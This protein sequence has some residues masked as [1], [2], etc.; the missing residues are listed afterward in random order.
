LVP[1]SSKVND[2]FTLNDIALVDRLRYNLLSVSQLVDVD[3]HVLFWKSDSRV[4]DS[5]GNLVCGV[6]RIGNIFQADFSL[7][8]S[9]LRCLLSQSS[10][11]LWK[12]HRR[13]DHLS[14]DLLC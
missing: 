1:A 2:H 13:L 10:S 6:S 4:L 7:T 9:S 8:Q 11:E 5:A 14:F 3:L 12:W